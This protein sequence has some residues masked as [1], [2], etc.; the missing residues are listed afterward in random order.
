MLTPRYACAMKAVDAVLSH[1]TPDILGALPLRRKISSDGFAAKLETPAMGLTFCAASTILA[2]GILAWEHTLTNEF[3]AYLGL[4]A[5]W[6]IIEI[7]F[8]EVSRAS[9][10]FMLLAAIQLTLSEVLILIIFDY[11][12]QLIRRPHEKA[13]RTIF[14][15]TNLIVAVGIANSVS[16]SAVLMPG[17]AINAAVAAWCYFLVQ[18]LSVTKLTFQKHMWREWRCQI[19]FRSW[20]NQAAL[21]GLLSEVL[22]GR[23]GSTLI[24]VIPA[25]L[26]LDRFATQSI[27]HWELLFSA[28]ELSSTDAIG[29]QRELR[30]RSHLMER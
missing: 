13:D 9:P 5:V 14:A 30:R 12:A 20:T 8:A 27:T 23:G 6:A 17:A 1:K 19:D 22:R 21:V 25:V 24:A 4:L 18:T 16:R 26:F 15:F 3:L 10:I 11:I 28:S 7:W 29:K 2:R